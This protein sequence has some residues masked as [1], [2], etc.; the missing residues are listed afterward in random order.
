MNAQCAV[1]AESEVVSLIHAKTTK[2]NIARAV[3]D[4]ISSRITAMVRKVGIEKEI[5]LVGGVARNIGFVDSIKRDLESD[6]LIPE[7]PE[8]IG[9]LGAAIAASEKANKDTGGD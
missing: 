2:E 5:A 6:V 7:D 8:Y 4:A 9:A 1:F 3:H